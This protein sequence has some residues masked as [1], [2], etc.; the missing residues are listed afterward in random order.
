M[1]K[2]SSLLQALGVVSLALAL[3]LAGCSSKAPDSDQNATPAADAKPGS[4]G[5]LSKLTERTVN[6][7]EGASITV[8]VDQTLSSNQSHSGDPF[9]A[10]VAEAVVIDGKTVVP[11]GARVKGTVVEASPSGRLEHPGSLAVALNS[12]EIGGKSYDLSTDTI[13]RKAG[14]H[15]TRNLEMIGGGA[16]A[17]A[18]IG[19]IA[20][21][22]KGAAIGAIAGAGAGTA[23]AA[24]TGKKDVSIPAETRLTFHLK[25]PLTVTVK[26]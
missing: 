7:P 13:S 14:S 16:G 4:G 21:H 23:G 5:I 1:R 20:G 24:I 25:Q 3:T 22:G 10:S 9:D 2:S 8:S 19:A 15:K 18:L 6:I 17:G 12:V 26:G 11:K